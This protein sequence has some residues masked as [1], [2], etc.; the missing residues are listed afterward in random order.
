MITQ[1]HYRDDP[2]F[3]DWFEKLKPKLYRSDGVLSGFGIKK[4]PD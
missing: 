2:K 4:F 1:I 3:R